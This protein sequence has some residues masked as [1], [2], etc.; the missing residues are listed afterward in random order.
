MPLEDVRE[1]WLVANPSKRRL[2]CPFLPPAHRSA[3]LQL[4]ECMQ[5]EHRWHAQYEERGQCRLHFQQARS[6]RQKRRCQS[7][8]ATPLNVIA[9]L[10]MALAI[11]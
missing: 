2:P 3:V 8:S 10:G 6:L 11:F 1:P 7:C 9:T 5:S 4:P